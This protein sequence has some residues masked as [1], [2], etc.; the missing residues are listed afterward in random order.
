VIRH[1]WRWLAAGLLILTMLAAMLFAAYLVFELPNG[2]GTL[3][4]NGEVIDLHGAHA[5]HWVVATCAVLAAMLVALVVVPAAVLLGIGLPA[6]LAAGALGAGLLLAGIALAAALSPLLLLAA[7]GVW[8][9][10]RAKRPATM[11]R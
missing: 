6:L 7:L 9:W 1:P 2:L 5:G 3:T 8:L 4:V 11:A 10:K